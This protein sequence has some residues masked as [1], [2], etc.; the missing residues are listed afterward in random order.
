MKFLVLLLSLC[1]LKC[2]YAQSDSVKVTEEYAIVYFSTGENGSFSSIH[3]ENLNPEQLK[4]LKNKLV[5]KS[6]VKVCN[7]LATEGWKLTTAFLETD[8]E[9]QELFYYSVYIFRRPV[10]PE[11]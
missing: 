5:T 10:R 4:S 11:N 3:I 1:T 9:G 8:K 2:A 6:Q 7:Y